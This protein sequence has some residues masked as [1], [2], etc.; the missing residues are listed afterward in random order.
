MSGPGIAGDRINYWGWRR[1]W[2]EQHFH[3]PGYVFPEWFIQDPEYRAL[4]PPWLSL[5]YGPGSLPVQGY[6]RG[7]GGSN[8]CIE[9]RGR[10]T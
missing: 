3:R 4:P 9:A 2:A 8:L 10:L 1:H 7:R 6:P 5:P